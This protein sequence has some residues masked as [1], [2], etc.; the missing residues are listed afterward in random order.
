[1]N[2]YYFSIGSKEFFFKTDRKRKDQ[3]FAQELAGKFLD[4]MGC[5]LPDYP[6]YFWNGLRPATLEVHTISGGNFAGMQWISID[7]DN[8]S[9]GTDAMENPFE[10]IIVL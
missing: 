10:K 3:A 4:K 7:G 9:F 5:K 8:F 2:G 1:M 6:H